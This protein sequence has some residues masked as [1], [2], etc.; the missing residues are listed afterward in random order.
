MYVCIYVFFVPVRVTSALAVLEM[1]DNINAFTNKL[2][3][4]ML[5]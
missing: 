4:D 2:L 3:D 1:V 5:K